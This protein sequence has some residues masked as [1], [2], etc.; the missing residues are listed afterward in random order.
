LRQLYPGLRIKV[1][2]EAGSEEFIALQRRKKLQYSTDSESENK[3]DGK[4]QNTNEKTLVIEDAS[5]SQDGEAAAQKSDDT[6]I[7]SLLEEARI[8]EK[9]AATV[10]KTSSRPSTA[11]TDS[12]NKLTGKANPISTYKDFV[13]VNTAQTAANEGH[14]LSADDQ[15]KAV[16]DALDKAAVAKAARATA[17]AATTALKNVSRNLPSIA[18]PIITS[19]NPKS[20]FGGVGDLRIAG[21]VNAIPHPL[22]R[23]QLTTQQVRLIAESGDVR[24]TTVA[25]SAGY[26]PTGDLKKKQANLGDAGKLSLK[27]SALSANVYAEHMKVRDSTSTPKKSNEGEDDDRYMPVAT[28]PVATLKGTTVANSLKKGKS[29]RQLAQSAKGIQSHVEHS[30][31]NIFDKEKDELH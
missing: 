10:N 22:E 9:E 6:L 28:S 27:G 13:K 14:M 7:S 18:T 1:E 24:S 30:L 29:L 19:P 8:K 26:L 21:D 23:I 11:K 20:R 2:P 31:S 25:E 4:S 15:L 5:I 12:S 3:S 17:Q 16:Q